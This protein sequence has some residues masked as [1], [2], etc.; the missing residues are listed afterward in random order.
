MLAL[1]LRPNELVV[2]A[3]IWGFTQDGRS[4]Y[5]GSIDYLRYWTRLTKPTLIAILKSLTELGLIERCEARG[6]ARFVSYKLGKKS[7]PIADGD[8]LKNFTELGKE[9]LP[10]N[11]RDISIKKENTKKEIEL[12]YQSEAFREAW[13]MLVRQPKWRSKSADALR[14]SAEKLGKYPESVAI[15]MM[16]Q[17]IQNGWQGL[18]ELKTNYTNGSNNTTS[19]RFDIGAQLYGED[20]L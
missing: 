2:Y 4:V 20:T 17:T 7:L 18:F 10:N 19:H 13:A 16:Q 8:R 12:P 1:E 5:S 6:D 15:A 14:M 11:K 3:L 9:I